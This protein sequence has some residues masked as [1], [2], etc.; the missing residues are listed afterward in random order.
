MEFLGGVIRTYQEFPD[1]TFDETQT[2]D[3]GT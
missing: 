1:K 2:E 3:I